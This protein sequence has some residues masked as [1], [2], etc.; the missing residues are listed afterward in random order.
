MTLFLY[1]VIGFILISVLISLLWFFFLITR[2][3]EV[4][5]HKAFEDKIAVACTEI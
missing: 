5:Y 4:E 1:A 2:P 3:E